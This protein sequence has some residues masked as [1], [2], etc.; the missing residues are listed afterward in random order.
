MGGPFDVNT[1]IS[2][3][4]VT[5]TLMGTSTETSHLAL[6]NDVHNPHFQV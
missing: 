5:P 3:N 4:T 2:I 6:H 1:H